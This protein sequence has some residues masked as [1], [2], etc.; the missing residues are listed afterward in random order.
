MLS[1]EKVFL[2]WAVL[3]C[4]GGVE[5]RGAALL[6]ETWEARKRLLYLLAP[7]A[8]R[9]AR[10]VDL[11]LCGR[12]IRPGGG[13]PVIFCRPVI[14]GRSVIFGGPSSTAG[15]SYLAFRHIRRPVVFCRLVIFAG[16]SY[17]AGRPFIFGRTV[18]FAGQSYSAPRICFGM[19]NRYLHC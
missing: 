19:P 16:P 12:H 3:D 13:G 2:C 9:G 1:W 15:P 10:Y 5:G 7:P 17:C 18:M 6:C 8:R 4:K 11:R 14:F